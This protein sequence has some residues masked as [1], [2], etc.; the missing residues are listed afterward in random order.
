VIGHLIPF[1]LSKGQD[2]FRLLGIIRRSGKRQKKIL[3][4][5]SH[6]SVSMAEDVGPVPEIRLISSPAR[7]YNI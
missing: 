1:L 4:Q 6:K 2:P 7:E 5:D 3:E